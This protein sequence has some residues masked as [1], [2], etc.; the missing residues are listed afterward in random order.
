MPPNNIGFRVSGL[1]FR[2]YGLELGDTFTAS[3]S[4]YNVS[5]F[6][7]HFRG[8]ESVTVIRGSKSN[9]VLMV[10]RVLYKSDI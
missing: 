1:R 5:G 8:A 9:Q 6:F 7:L 2:L 3:L 10:C 4:L